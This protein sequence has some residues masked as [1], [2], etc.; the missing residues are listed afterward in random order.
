ML[1]TV[2]SY[3]LAEVRS[4][5]LRQNKSKGQLKNCSDKE[6]TP[7]GQEVFSKF[8]EIAI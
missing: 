8:W 5:A 6:L 1:N 7:Y 3:Q 4:L 2:K